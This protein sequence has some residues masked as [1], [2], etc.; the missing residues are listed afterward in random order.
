MPGD[1]RDTAI[2]EAKRFVRDAVRND[3]EFVPSTSSEATRPTSSSSTSS[4]GTLYQNRQVS[5]WRCREFDSSGSELEPQSSDD[6]DSESPSGGK[7]AADTAIERRRRRR[8][9]MDEEMAWNE[10]MRMWMARRD[11]W[12]G[13][14]TRRQIR[15]KE[16][17]R[18]LDASIQDQSSVDGV[19]SG[20]DTGA[21]I[22]PP[23]QQKSHGE[24]AEGPGLATTIER[25]LSI[26]EKERIEESQ[27]R[28][29]QEE[30]QSTAPDDEK[31]KESTETSITEPD[32]Q[33]SND[34]SHLTTFPAINDSDPEEDEEELDEPL[35][36]VAPPFISSENPIRATIGPAIYPSIYTKVVV[37]GMTPTVPVNLADLT[38][39]MV[40]GWKADGQ[41]PPK[42]AVTS[43]VLQDD[44]SV[45][46]AA[47]SD[48]PSQTR[49][50]NS[51]TNA[52]RKVFQN[53]FHRRGST[54]AASGNGTPGTV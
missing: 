3:W 48:A 18:K 39:A 50:K 17:K 13:A 35:I 41:W 7:A 31:R 1:S 46:K 11:A 53:P 2:R 24:A 20:V 25:S 6:S 23:L 42:P 19:D 54:D 26:S 36:P 9:Q 38:K 29:E 43:I 45:P 27:R 44:A 28:Q 10:G 47:S 33:V 14:R 22:T 49:R 16:Q 8:R 30:G 4:T 21:G 12:S 5:E 32:A 51:I 40:Q 34:P 15:A 52:M 37:Q